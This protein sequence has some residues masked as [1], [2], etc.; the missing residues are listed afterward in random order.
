[1]KQFILLIN[2]TLF[3][4]SAAAITPV[5][6]GSWNDSLIQNEPSPSHELRIYPNPCKTGQ[7]TLEMDHYEMAEIRVINIAGKQVLQSIP[8]YGL[9]Q[10]RV[11]LEGIPDGIYF[12][13]VKTTDNKVVAKKL[14][15]SSH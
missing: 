10:H 14:I 15:I 12:M 5:L 6:T 13:R 7:V 1:M 4:L 8:E 3:Y 9:K 11:K 2:L